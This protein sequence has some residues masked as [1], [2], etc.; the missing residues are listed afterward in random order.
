MC[1]GIIDFARA[2]QVAVI[3]PFTLAS[4]DELAFEAIVSVEPGGHFSA[5][6]IRW[7]DTRPRFTSY[8]YPTGVISASGAKTAA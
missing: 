8:W 6:S 3:T 5:A 7:H 2:G 4:G 1:Q